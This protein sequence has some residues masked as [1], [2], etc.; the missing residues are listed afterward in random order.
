MF[1]TASYERVIPQVEND[2]CLEDSALEG[3][4]LTGHGGEMLQV[5]GH[6]ARGN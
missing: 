1:D 2:S 4:G 6:S 3:T 5:A